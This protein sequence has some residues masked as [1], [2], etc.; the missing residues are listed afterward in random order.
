MILILTGFFFVKKGLQ[1][2]EYLVVDDYIYRPVEFTDVPLYTWMQL[3]VKQPLSARK[4]QRYAATEKAMLA[5]CGSSDEHNVANELF[6]D[7]TDLDKEDVVE[8]PSIQ[9]RSLW[10]APQ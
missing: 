10:Q 1:Y 7:L 6:A 5:G 2:I 9:A 8:L 4:Q 3:N